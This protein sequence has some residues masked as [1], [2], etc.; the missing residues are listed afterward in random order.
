VVLLEPL[1][2]NA[3]RLMTLPHARVLPAPRLIFRRDGL[4]RQAWAAR[5]S[6][7]RFAEHHTDTRAH[8]DT[9]PPPMGDQ[10]P[11]RPICD[12]RYCISL[13]PRTAA[14]VTRGA[15]HSPSESHRSPLGH[16]FHFAA[17]HGEAP[18]NRADRAHLRPTCG[19]KSLQDFRAA[20]AGAADMCASECARL[21]PTAVDSTKPL[22]NWTFDVPRAA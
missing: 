11:E 1:V 7:D 22:R 5:F 3:V 10:E 13:P 9:Y 21:I 15:R 12:W 17:E 16:H 2:S 14:V 6:P 8:C 4:S 20:N 19:Q 18:Q